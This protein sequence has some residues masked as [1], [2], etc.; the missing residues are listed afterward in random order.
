MPIML[1]SISGANPGLILVEKKVLGSD[2]ATVTFSGLDGDTDETYVMRG[3]IS[4]ANS[5]DSLSLRPNGV[6]TG[7]ASAQ[8]QTGSATH[9]VGGVFSSWLVMAAWNATI[10]EG[11]FEITFYAK[12]GLSR[13]GSAT[14]RHYKATTVASDT[15]ILYHGNWSDAETNVTSLEIISSSGNRMLTGSIITLYKTA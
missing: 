8:H 6:S 5:T 12:S 1:S 14:Q 15:R 9:T 10:G 11:N 3:H 7:L 13:A 2:Q 4:L